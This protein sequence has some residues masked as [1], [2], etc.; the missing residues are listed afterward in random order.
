[1]RDCIICIGHV[2]FSIVFFALAASLFE[3]D[4]S[5]DL[6]GMTSYS[7]SPNEA[8][9][10]TRWVPD[11]DPSGYGEY[12]IYVDSTMTDSERQAG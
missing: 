3:C 11:L 1:M 8:I 10:W 2:G 4:F 5:A 9:N 7:E 12:F 6:C